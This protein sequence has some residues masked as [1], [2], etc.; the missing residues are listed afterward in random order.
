LNK[1]IY[2]LKQAPRQWFERLKSTLL[3]FGFRQS[4]CDPSLFVYSSLGVVIYILIY[5]DD[6]IL[7]GSSATLLQQ[8]ISQLN[9]IFALK[10]LGDLEYFL[11]IEVKTLNSQSLL[12]TQAKY[13]RDLLSKTDMEGCKLVASPMT[14][15]S[16]LSRDGSC[17]L[18]NP[19]HYRSV[20][21]A[22]QYLTIT[23]PD[24]TFAVNKVCQFMANPREDHWLAVK[25]ILRYLKGTVNFGLKLQA[26]PTAAPYSFCA[27][28]DA[29]WGMDQDDRRSTSG[30]CVFL[31][32][33]M[34]SWW[35][36]KQPVVSHSTTESEYCSLALATTEILWI[37][38]LLTEFIF[39]A[40]SLL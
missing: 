19:F 7:T 39:T 4:K 33:N 27:F 31:G 2:V 28:S 22:L 18:T 21:G 37:Q 13:I 1:A 15:G 11:G 14:A 34:I 12:L 26:L 36:K 17:L 20:V 32:S 23:R 25:R 8:L 30:V 6:I 9:A 29:D 16:K 10:Q 40:D 35:A 24:I 38:S 3:S 5:V